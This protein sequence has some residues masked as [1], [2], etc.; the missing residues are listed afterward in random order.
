MLSRQAQRKRRTDPDPEAI[1][2]EANIHNMNM[3][4]CSY[5]HITM[6]NAIPSTYSCEQAHMLL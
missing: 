2:K 1:E 5:Y 4:R 3:N 6:S